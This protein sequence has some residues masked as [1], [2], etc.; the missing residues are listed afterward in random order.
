MNRALTR[1]EIADAFRQAC[2]RELEALK[3]GNVH[4]FAAGH[5]MQV[6]DFERSAD[7]AA[8]HVANTRL[9]VGARIRRAIDATIDAVGCNTNLG[10]V[11]LCTP[12]A[13][14]S[15]KSGLPLRVALAGVL[16]GLDRRDAADAFVAILRANP[17]GL[18]NAKAA[19]VHG[20]AEITLKEAMALAARRDRIARAYVTQYADVFDFALPRL[21]KARARSGRP[22]EAITTLH[23]S[24]LAAFPDSHVARKHGLAAARWLQAA[25]KDKMPLATPPIAPGTRD[26]LLEFDAT[27]KAKGL[28]PG[29]TA[30]LVVA[31]LFVETINSLRA[32]PKG[33]KPLVE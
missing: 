15:S 18:G 29:T 24:L 9:K 6:K 10:I 7:A 16:D 4:I 27:L 26:R 8:P 19:D 12:L 31:T 3:P 21:A 11:L 33:R 32:R 25:A 22:E 20:P 23:M 2:Q 30:D 17:A 5:R 13:A 1:A 28:N 14:A